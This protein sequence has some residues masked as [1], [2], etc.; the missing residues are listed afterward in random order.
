M[1][2]STHALTPPAITSA[3]VRSACRER[4]IT[5][6]VRLVYV[7]VKVA[8]NR[9]GKLLIHFMQ[10]RIQ[11]KQDTNTKSCYGNIV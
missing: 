3:P 9:I 11:C 8:L 1:N 7:Y 2:V 4:G 6:A 5:A 10:A